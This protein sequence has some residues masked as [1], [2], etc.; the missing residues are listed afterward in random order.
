VALADYRDRWLGLLF[1]PRDFSLV[2]PT[3][4]TALS[5]RIT[6]F[7]ARECDLLGVSTDAVATHEQWLALPRGQGGLG[8]LSFPLA[9]DE[10]GTACRAYGVFLPRQHAALRGLFLIDPNGVLQYQAVH[11]LSVGRRTEEVLRVLDALQTGGLCPEGWVP[12][13][14]ALD[15]ASTLGPGSV[16]VGYRIEAALGSGSFGTVFRARDLTLQRPVALKVLSTA[17]ATPAGALLEEARAAAALLHPNICTVFAADMSEGLPMIV[18]EY[19][20]G[21]PLSQLLEGGPLPPGQ[22]AA[23]ARQVALGLAAAHAHGVVHAD[24]KPAN[25]MVTPDGTAKVMDFGLARRDPRAL[26][27]ATAV[28]ASG[29]S[30]GL[31]GTPCYMSPEQAHGA[32]LTPASDVFSLGLVLYE[33]LTGRRAIPGDNVLEVLRRVD[34][35]DAER[36]ARAVPEPFAGVL[37]QALVR[38]PAQRG[39]TM[40]RIAELLT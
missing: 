36:C 38:D 19:V 13:Q 29:G 15:P 30:R 40:A 37:R 25:I 32:A 31:S 2:C 1:Y 24:V 35:L 16:V 22:A 17:G 7:Q 12:G 4:L 27:A 6:E 21:R 18:M 26:A 11:N 28:L 33:M 14:A 39:L 5:G 34:D 9:A 3:E 20:D 23:V 10:D 8:G